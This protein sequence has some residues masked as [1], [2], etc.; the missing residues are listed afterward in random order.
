MIHIGH[1]PGY[2]RGAAG[3]TPSARVEREANAKCGVRSAE[4]GIIGES[5]PPRKQNE[6]CRMQ[7][8][9]AKSHSAG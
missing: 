1:A 6:E 4:C 9:R 2:H 3:K 7:K 8:S 5:G